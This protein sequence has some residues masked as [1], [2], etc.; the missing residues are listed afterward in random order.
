MRSVLLF[1]NLIVKPNYAMVL[2]TQKFRFIQIHV[3][4]L[5]V[6][7]KSLNTLSKFVLT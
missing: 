7:L 2:T 4:Y 6:F 3:Q 1:L 5:E